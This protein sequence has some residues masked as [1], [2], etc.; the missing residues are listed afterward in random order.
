MLRAIDSGGVVTGFVTTTSGRVCGFTGYPGSVQYLDATFI[1]RSNDAGWLVGY[2]GRDVTNGFIA[3]PTIPP[4]PEPQTWGLLL[5]GGLF[6]AWGA[7]RRRA[8]ATTPL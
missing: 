3:A 8:P 6:T 7:T 4:V 5:G 2:H 1:E